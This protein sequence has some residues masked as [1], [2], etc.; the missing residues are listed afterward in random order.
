MEMGMSLREYLEAG[1]TNGF[2]V[3]SEEKAN[4]VLRKIK[5][6]EDRKK[7]NIQ[8]ADAEVAKIDAW[9]EGVNE[10]LDNDLVHFQSMLA[11]Y[12]ERQR[13]ENPKFKSLKLPNG[14]IKFRKQQPKWNYEDN[15]VLSSLKLQGY[16][17]L[18]RIK[19]EVNKSE[20]KKRFH[21]SPDGRV[22]DVETGVAIEG[23]TVEQRPDELKIET[24]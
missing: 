12:A 13:E 24:E 2:V 21:V 1:E 10:E 5:A 4:W 16:E 20:M 14:K 11:T 3:D 19:E 6:L 9:L 7:G 23:V 15:V 17:D 8:L 22:V 18:I